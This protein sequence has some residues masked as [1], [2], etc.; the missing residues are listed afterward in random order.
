MATASLPTTRIALVTGAAQGIGEAI[1]LRLADDG[2]AV[3]LND[4][5]QKQ[6]LAAVVASA[7][8]RKGGRA[9]LV[10]GDVSVEGDVA[11]MIDKTV[12]ELG[13]LDVV[14]LITYAGPVNAAS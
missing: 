6:E 1:A 2:L 13:G 11:S 12:A 5:P 3:A 9:I 8:Q 10:L 14:S 7:I 4:I